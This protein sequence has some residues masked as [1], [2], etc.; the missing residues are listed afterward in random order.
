MEL[1]SNHLE[2]ETTVNYHSNESCL[3]EVTGSRLMHNL[4]CIE[5]VSL[6]IAISV[7]FVVCKITA[8]KAR[9]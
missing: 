1:Q 7:L 3:T 6:K 8:L 2:G 9:L 5:N 4:L